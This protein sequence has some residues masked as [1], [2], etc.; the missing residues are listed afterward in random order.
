M[1]HKTIAITSIVGLCVT[2]PLVGVYGTDGSLPSPL[3]FPPL[4]TQPGDASFSWW[5]F[6]IFTFFI[7]I[8]L[9]PFLV[10]IWEY[11]SSPIPSRPCHPSFPW[12]G[13]AALLWVLSGWILA[14][15]RFSW[16]ID[17]QP[18][19]FPI[20]WFGYIALVN[21]WTYTRSGACL[22]LHDTARFLKLFPLSAVCWWVFEYFNQFVHNWHYLHLQE[23]PPA[24]RLLLASISFSTVLPAVL[25][26]TEWLTTFPRFTAP[27][28]HW[29]RVPW[30]TAP[31]ARHCL[32]LLGCASLLTVGIWPTFLFPAIWIAPLLIILGYPLRKASP[33][34]LHSLAQGNWQPVVLPAMGALLCG[35][36]WECWNAFSLTHWHYTIPLVHGFQ[37]FHMPVLGYSGYLPFGL[38]CLAISELITGRMAA[39]RTSPSKCRPNLTD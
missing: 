1:A 28:Q 7:T 22:L 6:G 3:T 10:R 23:M 27:F 15:T 26:T 18:H 17:I 32:F 2:L 19:T 24:L 30:I 14:W 31:I 39:T 16:M 11:R 8:T 29:H 37:L 35:F 5:V 36:W 13:W 33:A 12:W 34:L 21:A 25:S 9:S 4:L 38:E 20:L